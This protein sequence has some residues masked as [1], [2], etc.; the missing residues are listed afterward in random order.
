[1]ARYNTVASTAS[2]TTTA[3]VAA[4]QAGLLTTFGGAGPYTVT[5]ANPVLYTGQTQSFW[6]NS[7]GII[8]LSTPSGNIKGAGLTAGTSQTM[9]NQAFYSLT[10][11][12][13][14]YVLSNNE[15]GPLVGTTGT[16]TGTLSTSGTFSV[17][18]SSVGLSGSNATVTISPSGTGNVTISPA[19]ALTMQPGGAGTFSPTGNLT[20]NPG[21]TLTIN[22]TG[23]ATISGSSTL[24]LGTVGQTTTLRGNLDGSQSNQTVTFS[25]TGTGGVTISPTGTSSLTI[26][27][28]VAGNINNMNVGASTRGSGA[29]TSLAANGTVSFSATSATHTISSTTASSGTGSGALVI[30]G[31]LGVAGSMYAATVVETSSITFKENVNPLTNALDAV[32]QLVGVTYD[33]KDGLTKNEVGLIAEEV[34][35]VAPNLVTLD[36]KG[37]PYGLYYTKITAYLI[38]SIKSLKTEIDELKGKN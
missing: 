22:P 14:D 5:L 24:T 17:T 19:A 38:E 34:Y 32:L 23:A 33:R 11:D 27:P 15:G 29:F 26:N 30:S 37:N 2:I 7:G 9:A 1:M 8:T 35:K 16:F 20:M 4:P 10:S 3:T 6:N 36:E 28:S 25:P 21:G 13:T 12:G 18:G 31:G